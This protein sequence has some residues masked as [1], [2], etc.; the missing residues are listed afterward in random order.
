MKKFALILIVGFLAVMIT[1]CG[2]KDSADKTEDKSGDSKDSTITVKHELGETKV[3]KNP[4]KVVV[5][6]YGILD[7]LDELGIQVAA[8]PQGSIPSYLEKYDSDDY[9][10]VGSLKEPDFEKIA[11]VDPDLIIISGRQSD[12][13][14]QLQEIAPTIYLGVDTTRYMDSFK[15]NMET[16]GKIFDKKDEVDQE[17]TKI[18]DSI[19]SLKKKAEEV[20]KKGLIILANDDK[21]SAYGPDSR[22]GLIHD[23]FGVPAS[24]EDIEASTHGQNVSFEYVKEQ[25]PDLLYVVDR[26]AAIGDEPAAKKI[27][28]NKLM[29]DTKAYKNDDITYLNPEF[30]YLS[31]GGLVSVQE[32]IKEVQDSLD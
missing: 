21:I 16:V 24:D 7:T 12:V 19:A 29:K 2:S 20:D 8:V 14:D 4:K 1:A 28:E 3:E 5:F 23:V 22:F 13:Y 27:V 25:D 18:D 11:E 17:L 32:M 26:S 30:W 31:G 9:E 15:E 10:N 6:D